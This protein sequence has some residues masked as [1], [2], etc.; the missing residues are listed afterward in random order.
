M[1]LMFK[2]KGILDYIRIE[3]CHFLSKK[4]VFS[5]RIFLFS[6]YFG[7]CFTFFWGPGS[8]ESGTETLI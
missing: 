6:E 8:S 7:R 4:K 1:D 3:Y 2:L 5:Q